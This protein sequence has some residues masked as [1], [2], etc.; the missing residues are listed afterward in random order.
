METSSS[1]LVIDDER[2]KSS[3]ILDALLTAIKELDQ[4]ME[5]I[6]CAF[7]KLTSEMKGN[8]GEAAGGERRWT[9]KTDFGKFQANQIRSLEDL[10]GYL[11]TDLFFEIVRV[12]AQLQPDIYEVW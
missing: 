10:N 12:L 5:T 1:S 6:Q 4:K 7:R 8:N 2:R 3:A 11:N 9:H